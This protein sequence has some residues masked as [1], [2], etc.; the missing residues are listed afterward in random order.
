M[1]VE[2]TGE[3]AHVDGVDV[4]RQQPLRGVLDGG[5]AGVVALPPAFIVEALDLAA[6]VPTV[7]KLGLQLG[8]AFGQASESVELRPSVVHRGFTVVGDDGEGIV[9]AD[10]DG[11]RLGRVLQLEC[12]SEAIPSLFPGRAGWMQAG[13]VTRIR[14]AASS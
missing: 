7:G 8:D 3:V 11:R 1:S 14:S 12:V 5:I 4:P 6:R 2:H 9:R 13:C 10:I